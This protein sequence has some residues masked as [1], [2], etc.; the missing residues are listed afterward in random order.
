MAQTTIT[1]TKAP[2]LALTPTQFSQQHF[3]L[4]NQQLRVYFNT[5]DAFNATLSTTDGGSALSFP[6]IGASDS[7]DQYAT[8]DNTPTI[9]K[10]NT[11]EAASGFTLNPNNYATATYAGVYKIDYSLQFAN[12][13][14][15]Q[16][17]V[18]VWLRVNGVDVPGSTSKFSIP[19][20]KS[21]LLPTYILAVSF[22]MFTLNAGDY[23]E[24]YWA[25]DQ[26]YNPVGP[27]NGV[28][29]EYKAAQTVP[30]AH[31]SI[32]SAI[33]TITFVSRI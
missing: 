12:T 4:L 30:Y 31:P 32:P 1:T 8:A 24:L 28:Y 6:H 21:A 20:R 16:H 29:M 10:W 9:V 5:L 2:A 27:V 25:T 3:D 33:G 11:L 15:A 13:A 14:N 22:V 18:D 23:L 26:A 19:A 7:T 17:D